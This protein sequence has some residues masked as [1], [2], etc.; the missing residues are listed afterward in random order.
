MDAN[1]AMP[2]VLSMSAMLTP[3]LARLTTSASL[4]RKPSSSATSRSWTAAR[5]A[6]TSGVTGTRIRSARPNIARLSAS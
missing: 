3:L 1:A 4:A 2:T 5:R 6:G